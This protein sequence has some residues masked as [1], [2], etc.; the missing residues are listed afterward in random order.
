MKFATVLFFLAVVA[1]EEKKEE[2]TD[3]AADGEKR[4]TL[5]EGEDC[6]AEK[7]NS[8]CVKG[9]CCG[10][11]TSMLGVDI[12]SEVRDLNKGAGQCAPED[13]TEVDSVLGKIGY[14]CGATTLAASAVAAI[15]I[16]SNL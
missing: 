2:K 10:Q 14:E 3:A 1:A 7:E 4:G 16:V 8:G 6:N 11:V 5:K 15:A 9:M 13:K 12:P